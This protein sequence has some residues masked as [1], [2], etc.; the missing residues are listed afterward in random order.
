MIQGGDFTAGNGSGGESIYGDK[1]DDEYLE[2]KH[3]RPG[4][5][6]MANAGPNTNGSQFF[7]TCVPTPHLDEKHVVFGQVVKGMAVVKFIENIRVQGECPVERC[8]IS[9]CGVI[10]S[11]DDCGLNCNDGTADV[12]TPF[13]EDSEIDMTDYETVIQ[14][15]EDIKSSGNLFFKKEDFI[16]AGI[17]YKKALRYLNKLHEPMEEAKIGD[18]KT[19]V[20]PTTLPTPVDL[21]PDQEKRLLQLELNC[22]LNS[23]ACKLKQ[24]QYESALEDCEEALDISP[25]NPKAWFRKGQ[26]LH[27]LREYQESLSCLMRAQKLSPSDKAINSEIVAVRG[28][29]QAYKNLEKKAY[30]KLFN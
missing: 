11:I 16:T 5:L 20:A 27:G 13:P 10:P 1:F 9:N 18:N 17:K 28:E 24:R 3:D 23:A 8:F 19:A 4:L 30:S 12:F 14:V 6:S 22:L 25:E 26:A 2:L 7:I 21:T 29:I 15:G